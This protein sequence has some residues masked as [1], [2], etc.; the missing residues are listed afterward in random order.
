MAREGL[1][2]RR[3]VAGAVVDQ[4][5]HSRPLVLGSIFARRL[6]FEHATRKRA[7]ERL[8]ARFDLVVV[9][10]PVH[11]LEVHVGAGGLRKPLEEIVDQLGLQIADEAHRD[12]GVDHGMR[13]AAQIDRGD[14]QRFVH[15]HHEVAGA[16]DAALV[17]DRR[18]HRLA[19]RNADVFDGVMLIDV[20]VAG[21]LHL[22][23]EAAMARDEIQHV[24]E[25]AD[26]GAVVVAAL[27]VERQRDLDL[28]FRRAPIDYRVPG[29]AVALAKAAAQR[30][31]RLDGMTRVFDHAGGQPE[32]VRTVTD[33]WCDRGRTRPSRSCP[34]MIARARGPPSISTK[35]AA[36]FQ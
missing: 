27:A 20:E 25:K 19:E 23:I 36:L 3:Q 13:A 21:G 33:P 1:S 9:R 17:A 11:H 12:L 8:E 16:V 28:R 4:R 26:A 31:Q 15:R 7:R 14:R 5:D 10:A 18:R 30:L 32:A 22:E 2:H 34:S 6:S 24:I 35:L 29:R